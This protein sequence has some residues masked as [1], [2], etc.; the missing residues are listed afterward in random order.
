MPSPSSITVTF[1]DQA[2]VLQDRGGIS[3]LF[4]ELMREFGTGADGVTARIPMRYTGNQHLIDLDPGRFR[5]PPLALAKQ[6][7]MRAAN[8]VL[9]G[10][11]RPADVLHHTYYFGRPSPTR[12]RVRV[13]TVYDMIPEMF[14]GMFGSIDPH[15]NKRLY[16]EASDAVLCISEATKIDL[17]RLYDGLDVPVFVTPLGVG[18]RFAVP[19]PRPRSTPW[20]YLIHVGQRRLYKNFTTVLRAFATV[21]AH[22]PEVRLV[23]IGGEPW[24][25]EDLLELETWGPAIAARVVR[26]RPDDRD[27]PSVYAAADAYVSASRYEGFGLPVLEAMAAGTPAVV[28]DLMSHREVGEDAAVY[29]PAEDVGALVEQ[30]NRVRALGPARAAVVENGRG[31]AAEFTWAR[32]ASRTAAAYRSV[33]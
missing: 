12:A 23:C 10:I 1:D 31:R 33:L 32:T 24:E 3:R 11:G 16:V 26:L 30:V 18:A 9:A 8:R 17:L 14:P 25:S 22:D 20:P 6:P 4:T 2:F 15:R 5:H 13:C 21:A 28:S 27:L 7:L 19:G 29:F